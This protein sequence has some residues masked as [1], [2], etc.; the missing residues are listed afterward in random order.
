MN[1][2]FF[3]EKKSFKRKFIFLLEL[4]VE[5]VSMIHLLRVVEVEIWSYLLRYHSN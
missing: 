5:E 3:L 1:R 2:G 4:M